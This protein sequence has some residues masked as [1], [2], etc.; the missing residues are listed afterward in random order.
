MDLLLRRIHLYAGL[1][2]APWFLMY[3]LSSIPF[4]H[5]EYFNRLDQQKGLPPFT[6][7]WERPYDV[8]VPENDRDLR[9]LGARIMHDAG[10]DGNFGA[11][12]VGGDRIEVY[13]YTFWKSTTLRYFINEKKLRSDPRRF[14]WDQFFTGMHA[15]GGFEQDGLVNDGWALLVDLV[16]V[17]MLAWIAT[18]LYLWWGIRA[19]RNWGWLALA[20]GFATFAAF[21]LVL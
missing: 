18:G 6:T 4:N 11:Y 2:L 16:C 13:V 3:S 20:A 5:N 10:L 1:F 21:L 8:P 15:R 17:G 7:S 12:R 9:A 19:I 14:R